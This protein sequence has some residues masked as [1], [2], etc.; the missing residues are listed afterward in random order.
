MA[1]SGRIRHFLLF[2]YIL[3]FLCRG[4]NQVR[5][6]HGRPDM[7]V[8][9]RHHGC[10]LDALDALG[11][12]LIEVVDVV[13]VLEQVDQIADDSGH[14]RVGE[15]RLNDYIDLVH[16][17]LVVLGHPFGLLY[18]ETLVA[19]RNDVQHLFEGV[20]VLHV[21]NLVNTTVTCLDR[22]VDSLRVVNRHDDDAGELLR[23][24][25]VDAS[26]ERRGK[27]VL[28]AEVVTVDVVEHE[29]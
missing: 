5:L 23:I 21:D 4:D 17:L 14:V 8:R 19:L 1:K 13:S 25:L 7:A 18:A 12:H 27:V 16:E 22:R 26:D 9:P 20:G 28:L 2:S 10:I 11:D 29:D 6:G 3:L 24:G 15:V